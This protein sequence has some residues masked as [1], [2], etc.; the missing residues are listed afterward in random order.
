MKLQSHNRR[1]AAVLACLTIGVSPCRIASA[2]QVD[3]EGRAIY[4][5]FLTEQRGR[6]TAARDE[7]IEYTG[8]YRENDESPYLVSYGTYEE[9]HGVERITTYRL[10]VDDSSK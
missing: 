2:Q 5:R 8:V 6:E 10:L 3:N 9:D 1:R 7:G 4:S